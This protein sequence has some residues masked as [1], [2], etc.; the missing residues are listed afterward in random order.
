[1]GIA[2]RV[3]LGVAGS[4]SLGVLREPHQVTLRVAAISE[5]EGQTQT[6]IGAVYSRVWAGSYARAGLGAGLGV[7]TIKPCNSPDP[8]EPRCARRIRPAVP[9]LADVFL[10]VLPIAGISIQILGNLSTEGATAAAIAGVE[11]GWFP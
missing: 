9:Y 10:R 7:A 8:R 3:D 2:P 4:I 5:I 6:D 1:L 11:L